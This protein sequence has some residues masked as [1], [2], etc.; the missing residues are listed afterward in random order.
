MNKLTIKQKLI[1]LSTIVL[2]IILIYSALI[3]FDAYAKY[4]N[5]SQ[6]NS[7]IKLSV[8]MS[9]LLHELQKERGASAGYIG[10]NGKKFSDI[11]HVQQRETDVKIT[12]LKEFCEQCS[13]EEAKTALTKIDLHSIKGMREK[14]NRMNT[15]VQETVNF[16]TTINR[17]I[18]NTIT[19]FSTMP[20]DSKVR[21]DFSAFVIFISAKERAG[22]E[23][24]VLSGVFAKDKFSIESFAK[25]SSLAAEQKT[26]LNLFSHSA[27]KGIQ[28]AF[29][30]TKEDPSFAEVDRLRA[31]AFSKKENFGV[32]SVYWFK[33]ITRKINQLKSFENKIAEVTLSIS[34][35]NAN[36]AFITLAVTI[37]LSLLILIFIIYILRNVTNSISDSIHKFTKLIDRVNKGNLSNLELVG[38]NNDEMGELAKMLSSLVGTFHMLIQRINTSVSQAAKGDFS[39][40]LNDQ[41]LEGDFSQAIAMVSSGI[42]AMKDA[43]TKQQ[44]INF[45]ASIQGIGNV[46]DGLMLIQDEMVSVIEELMSVQKTT[47]KTSEQSSNS[48]QEVQAIVE[49]LQRLVTHISDSNE[50]IISL[51]NQTSEVASVVDLIKDIADQTNLL[52]LNAAIEAAR[53]GEHGRGFAVVADEVRKLAER[54]QKATS[55]ITISI[56]SMKQEANLIQDK[57]QRMTEL[58][59]ESSSSVENFNDTMS[60]LNTDAQNMADIVEKMESSVFVTLA[61]IDH[62]IFK[63]TAYDTIVAADDTVHFTRHTECRL[64]KWYETTGKV[65]FGTTDAYKKA[66]VPHK[67]VHDMVHNNLLY[68]Q[69]GDTRVENQEII[70]QNFKTM[71]AASDEL[72]VLLDNMIKETQNTH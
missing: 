54:T 50:N 64:G 49:K 72:F 24:A 65:R 42:A 31:I 38:F 3:S 37:I 52:A 27:S 62:I 68:L 17:S 11:I 59:E 21:T 69:N 33:T 23:R 46:G 43:H 15:T 39:Y 22:V 53:A 16:Y 60:G 28:E 61:K 19:Y 51:N 63:A 40:D 26:L 67:N 9:A 18:I 71:E 7:I 2:S 48:M 14:I 45:N 56:N 25:F 32:D 13:L 20:K 55:E 58:A 10:S 36:K 35:T 1:L 8:K 5:D 41:N 34:S 66:I 57:S 29:I 12:E 70:T 47:K 4:K 44:L 6:S 30:K